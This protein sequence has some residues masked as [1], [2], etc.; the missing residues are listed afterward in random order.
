MADMTL[1]ESVAQSLVSE[2]ID[3]KLVAG[4]RL[5]EQSI[6]KRF[7]VSRSP[8]RDA[9]RRLVATHLVEY[10]PRRGFSVTHVDPIKL[11]DMYDALGEIEAI[12]ASFC[13]LRAR[14]MD[15]VA[16]ERIHE[17]AK[18]AAIAF[19][20]DTY[21]GLNEDFHRAI[22]SGAR[23]KTLESVVLDV[24]QRLAPFRSRVFF[25]RTRLESSIQEHDAIL[26]AIL[27]H[28]AE[29][30]AVAMRIHTA[31]TAANVIELSSSPA[32]SLVRARRAR[33]GR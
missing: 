8:V 7:K 10:A 23:N 26:R 6:A 5:D 18:K 31:S 32:P 21:A 28:D 16:L 14:S 13:A 33:R 24:R 4:K 30:A 9:L 2:I 17:A 27:S 25:Q 22:Y 29:Q 3:G 12:C 20:S 1:S 15:R 11:Q 19:A